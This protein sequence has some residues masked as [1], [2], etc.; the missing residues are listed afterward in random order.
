MQLKI[1]KETAKK[2]YNESPDWSKEIL[3][4]TFGEETFKPKHFTDFKTFH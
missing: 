4:E 3:V 1:K 2:R